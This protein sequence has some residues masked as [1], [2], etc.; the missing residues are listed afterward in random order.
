[1][2]NFLRVV[3][4]PYEVQH[5]EADALL[6]PVDGAV[7]RLGGGAARGLRAALASDERDEELGDLEDRL[8][9][10]RLIPSSEAR[11]VEGV[12]RWRWIVVSAAYAH[13]VDG[14]LVGPSESAARVRA[15]LPRALS[16]AVAVGE[17]LRSLTMTL[18][19]T[20]Y[21]MPVELA[22][23]AEADGLAAARNL[24]LAVRWS[25][26][27]PVEIDLAREACERRG[28]RWR[29]SDSQTTS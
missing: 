28:L 1:M 11:L 29:R 4:E 16:V 21:R 22:V 17:G 19:G 5:V 26:P 25:L 9:R 13:N 15:A 20:A 10:L 18:V 6:L 27:R 8:E 24:D 3:L 12:A 14:R 7:C 2:K 23:C